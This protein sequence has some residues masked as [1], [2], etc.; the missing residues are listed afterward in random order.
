MILE[1]G[2]IFIDCFLFP[3]RVQTDVYS[4]TGHFKGLLINNEQR[5]MEENSRLIAAFGVPTK[6]KP[7]S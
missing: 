4:C 3:F 6:R 7:S 5:K 2:G 1:A